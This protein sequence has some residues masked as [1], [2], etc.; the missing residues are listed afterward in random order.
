VLAASIS[1]GIAML[2]LGAR[3]G[4]AAAA[5]VAVSLAGAASFGGSA[6]RARMGVE[7]RAPRGAAA[8]AED[9]GSRKLIGEGEGEEGERGDA[10]DEEHEDHGLVHEEGDAADEE[11]VADPWGD[12]HE[13]YDM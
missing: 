5:G 12:D 3:G 13:P 7:E 6:G 2:E 8:A 11:P 4:K 9:P 1:W 10:T